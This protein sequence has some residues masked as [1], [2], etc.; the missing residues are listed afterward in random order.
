[1]T[2]ELVLRYGVC[3]EVRASRETCV[4]AEIESESESEHIVD[5]FD[6]GIDDATGMPFLAMELQRGEDLG[7]RLKRYGAVPKCD[8]EL[9]F[10]RNEFGA[11]QDAWRAHCASRLE[12]RQFVLVRT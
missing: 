6:A 5:V 8:V 12:T 9:V 3:Q 1:M 7:K 4:A 10:V 2:L 11:R